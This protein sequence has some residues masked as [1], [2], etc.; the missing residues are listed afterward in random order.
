[1]SIII[2]VVSVEWTK[3]SRGAP[4]AVRRNAVPESLPI[5]NRVLSI[6]EGDCF[7]QEIRCCEEGFKPNF[8]ERYL[9]P[10]KLSLRCIKLSVKESGLDVI[11]THKSR[12]A[13]AP[14]RDHSGRPKKAFHCRRNSG[15]NLCIMDVA[16]TMTGNGIIAR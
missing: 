16:G 9:P 13:G 8:R 12:L 10:A 6:K 7:I 2:Q 11:Y 3:K 1:M 14:D 4:G 15:G 5:V